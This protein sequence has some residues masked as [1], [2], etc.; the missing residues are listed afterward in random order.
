MKKIFIC[1]AAL[2]MTTVVFAQKYEESPVYF[3]LGGA[4]GNAQTKYDIKGTDY[5]LKDSSALYSLTAGFE[6]EDIRAEFLYQTRG[7]LKDSMIY[8]GY[9]IT[10]EMDTDLYM[11]NIKF[12]APDFSPVIVPYIGVGIGKANTDTSMMVGGISVSDSDATTVY[13]AY[14]GFS[15]KYF[16]NVVVDLGVDLYR[17]KAFEE[18]INNISPH[19]GVRVLFNLQ[20]EYI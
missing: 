17:F 7:T 12:G 10:G 3:Y 13:G 8:S 18:N 11:A 19:I 16:Q 4:L 14:A 9:L 5:T 2:C 20:N 15:V 1:L 6:W